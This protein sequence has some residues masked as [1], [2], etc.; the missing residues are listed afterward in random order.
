ML[1]EA[2]ETLL[3]WDDDVDTVARDAE[4]VTLEDEE[5]GRPDDEVALVDEDDEAEAG[6]PE[7]D[8]DGLTATTSG[9]SSNVN[10][11]DRSWKSAFR[12]STISSNA[13]R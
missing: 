13:A 1:T 9:V 4:A 11:L 6:R 8:D 10:R 2:C 7:E 5:L 3:S 12:L